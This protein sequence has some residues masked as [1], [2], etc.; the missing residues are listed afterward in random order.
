MT[1][2]VLTSRLLIRKSPAILE[3]LSGKDKSLLIGRNA[4]FVLDFC[5]DIVDRI[6]RFN[7]EGNRLASQGLDK[8]LHPSAEAEDKMER[9][10]LL[11]VATGNIH[12]TTVWTSRHGLLVGKSAPIFELLAGKDQSLLVGRDTFLV[13]NLR[14]HVVDSIGRLDF[15]RDRLARQGLDEDLHSASETQDFGRP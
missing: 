15:E 8:D 11:N 12:T 4:L 1:E 13:L 3:L 7:L 14:L 2:A 9:R 10:L 6:R 5:L